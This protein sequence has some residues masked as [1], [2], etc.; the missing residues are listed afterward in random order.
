MCLVYVCDA[1]G[2][3]C[4]WCVRALFIWCVCVSVRVCVCVWCVDSLLAVF[5]VRDV[6]CVCVCFSCT[7]CG[8]G[9][10]V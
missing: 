1:C 3:V 2:V 4:L 9:V 10:S 7:L 5:E 6:V 8:L